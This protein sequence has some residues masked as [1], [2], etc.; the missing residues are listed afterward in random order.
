MLKFPSCLTGWCQSDSFDIA[1]RNALLAP[2]PL[3][4]GQASHVFTFLIP[5]FYFG[6][7]LVRSALR[8]KREGK[9]YHTT[10][11]NLSI[12]LSVVLISFGFNSYC[13]QQFHRQRPAFYFNAQNGTEFANRPEEEFLSFYSGDATAGFTIGKVDKT[14][15]L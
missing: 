9:G 5:S 13:K 10:L 3:L 1:L 2:N 8:E 12:V 7:V 15:S 4:A 6:Y 11:S 14:L